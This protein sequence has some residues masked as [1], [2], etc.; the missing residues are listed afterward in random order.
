MP[1][2]L[3]SDAM[4]AGSVTIGGDGGD[5]IEAYLAR[6]DAVTPRGG[7]IVI[8]HMPGYDRATKEI[9]RRFAELGYDAICPNLYWREAPGAA[10]DDAAATARAQGGVP[11]ERLSGDV[12]GAA[13]YLRGL[14]S[15]N[16]KVGVIGYC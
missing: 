11:D 4:T 2:A 6:P 3:R 10:P 14:P 12:G 8:H 9:T 7:V 1:D 5:E 15:S 13:D 16:G